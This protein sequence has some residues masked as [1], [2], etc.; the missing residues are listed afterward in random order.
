VAAA[1]A[2]NKADSA[3]AADQKALGDAQTKQ[4]QD[5]AKVD[6]DNAALTAAKKADA[7]EDTAAAAAPPRTGALPTPGAEQPQDQFDT[8]VIQAQAAVNADGTID[9]K[10]DKTAVQ[11]ANAQLAIDQA[12]KT[13][14]DAALV[15]AVAAENQAC[16]TT[17][18][19]SLP[20]A[21]S[22]SP[23]PAPASA[24]PSSSNPVAAP[25]ATQVSAVVP[26]SQVPTGSV[27]TGWGA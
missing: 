1:D 11:K 15:S 8:A 13:T 21:S 27:D 18:P 10:A 22:S 26:A 7:D 3:V 2:A 5:V 4:N 20:P 12:T 17:V 16:A 19:T 25:A 24:A 9:L 23:A 6:T 14:A